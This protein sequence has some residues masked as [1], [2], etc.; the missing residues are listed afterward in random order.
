MGM[1]VENG[2][3]MAHTF[4]HALWFEPVAY[5]DWRPNPMFQPGPASYPLW[6]WISPY[7]VFMRDAARRKWEVLIKHSLVPDY[8]IK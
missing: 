1:G 5:M 6:G 3:K 8:I 4:Q 7:N 2:G